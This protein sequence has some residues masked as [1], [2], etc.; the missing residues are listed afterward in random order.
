MFQV[1]ERKFG[2][3]EL[4]SQDLEHKFGDSEHN[5]FGDLLE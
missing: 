2:V 4:M 3:F 5:F 1:F